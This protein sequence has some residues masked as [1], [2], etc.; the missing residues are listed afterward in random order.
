MPAKDTFFDPDA[1]R[2]LGEVYDL[3]KMCEHDQRI[4]Y[5]DQMSAAGGS[6]R[7]S[8]KEEFGF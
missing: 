4:A 5:P 7:A 2:D 6:R 3:S 1:L 8:G